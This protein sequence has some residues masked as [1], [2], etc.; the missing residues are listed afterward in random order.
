M[1]KSRFIIYILCLG[2]LISCKESK[3]ENKYDAI[4]V[5]GYIK[6]QLNLLDSIPYGLLKITEKN[7]GIGDSV[8]LTKKEVRQLIDPFI[9]QNIK[10][11]QLEKEYTESSFA[12]A[13]IESVVI[14]YDAK[15]KDVP[16]HQ[17][18]LYIR[19]DNGTIN[20]VYINGNFESRE[21]E[22][23]KQLLWLNN[24][25]FTIISSPS[26]DSSGTETI[27]EKLIWQ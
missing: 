24:K 23:K 10:K 11:D 16:I 19:P 3:K 14:T 18:T 27:T 17:I 2:F 21:W 1:I 8:Y 20:K 25:G 15:K 22:G 6:G 12:D 13:T 5:V 4:D 26:N 7:N 9:N